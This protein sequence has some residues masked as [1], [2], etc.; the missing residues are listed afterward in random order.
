M[1]RK[2]L[3][4]KF[5]MLLLVITSFLFTGC[6]KNKTVPNYSNIEIIEIDS[7]EYIDIRTGSGTCVIHK[8]NCKFCIKRNNK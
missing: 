3:A 7:C 6:N 8:G 5:L 2:S 1:K 4:P